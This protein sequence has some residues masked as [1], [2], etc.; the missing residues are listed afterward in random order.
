M[1]GFSN[2]KLLLNHLLDHGCPANSKIDAEVDPSG[3]LLRL[4]PPG[5]VEKLTALIWILTNKEPEISEDLALEVLKRDQTGKSS[6]HYQL[7]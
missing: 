4:E 2:G 1:E 6:L 7:D 3:E 5:G